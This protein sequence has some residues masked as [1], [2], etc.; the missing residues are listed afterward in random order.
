MTGVLDALAAGPKSADELAKELGT[1]ALP[2]K[3]HPAS[4]APC[5]RSQNRCL[6]YTH[7]GLAGSRAA[8][9]HHT[10]SALTTTTQ[11]HAYTAISSRLRGFVRLVPG[12]HQDTLA[13][14]LRAAVVM[15]LLGV[16]RGAP[17]RFCNTALSSTLLDSNPHSIWPMA[18]S[19]LPPASAPLFACLQRCD[20]AHLRH[21]FAI[22]ATI[23]F[24]NS[25]AFT[26]RRTWCSLAP[27]NSRHITSAA[28]PQ[29]RWQDYGL[30][31][32]S[33]LGR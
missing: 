1:L 24:F 7:R 32:M 13:R 21:G 15:R 11:G 10:T 9:R 25:V 4:T 22:A 23:A 30:E 12:L 18:R 5:P 28:A 33:A 2:R 31:S 3:M 6:N 20:A 27:L 17:P 26:H 14:V 19:P 8:R 16:D 29:P